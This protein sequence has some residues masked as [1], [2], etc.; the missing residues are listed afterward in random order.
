MLSRRFAVASTPFA[1]RIANDTGG[2]YVW[3]SKDKLYNHLK[4]KTVSLIG[5]PLAAG[6]HMAGVEKGPQALR[7]AGLENVIRDLGWDFHD[8][9]DLDIQA[10]MD[11][12][13][14][15]TAVP[16][17]NNCEKIGHANQ[18]I[19][20]AVKKEAMKGNFV[21]NVGGDHS[22]GSATVSAMRAVHEDLCVIW[23]DAHADCN[24]PTTSPSGNYHGMPVAHVLN[25]I[26]PPLPRWEWLNA[27]CMLKEQ[28]LALIGLRDVD[29]MER[30]LLRSSG[31]H[32]FGM[33]EV[34]R[35][36]IGQVLDM[37]LHATNPHSDRP[38]HISFDI[39]S[40]DPSIA[41]G[42]GTCSRGGLSFRE[43]HYIM[44][45]LSMTNNVVSCDLVE[46]NPNLDEKVTGRL[47]GDDPHINTDYLTVRLA[48]E[49]IASVLGKTIC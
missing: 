5:A 9:G 3:R 31:C 41:P 13:K 25:W 33:H 39:D 28:R 21:L 11:I 14:G 40:C 38:I 34:D 26:K 47:H 22:I 1:R 4:H 49:L 18:L 27:S 24:T 45:R 23:V 2:T 44:E 36:G 6:Q 29:A 32:A 37:A 35:Y 20:E 42:T 43:A 30:Q 10:A 12:F 19:H 7:D 17:V 8:V 48:T 16:R 15:N 46:V